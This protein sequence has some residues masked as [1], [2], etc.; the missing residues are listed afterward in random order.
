V[1]GFFNKTSVRR[2]G[3]L[4]QAST[5]LPPA[6]VVDRYDRKHLTEY[7]QNAMPLEFH[8]QNHLRKSL[9]AVIHTEDE[10]LDY[11]TRFEYLFALNGLANG[12]GII[13]GS[14]MWES[15]IH[16]KFR[17]SYFHNTIPV[18]SETNAE[19]ER[20]GPEWLPFRDGLFSGTWERFLE[21]KKESDEKIL[22]MAREFL[23]SRS[24]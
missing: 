4:H 8:L 15:E 23:M 14:Y 11:F 21:F 16:R 1:A 6:T 13:L 19:I 12:N 9:S 22:E 20:E 7:Q 3:I 18:I 2:W 5:G 17:Q 24:Y 10:Y